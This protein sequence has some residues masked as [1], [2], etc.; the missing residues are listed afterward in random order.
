M[1]R[2]LVPLDGSHL[3]ETVLPDA[4]RL[5]GQGGELILIR[6]ASWTHVDTP[7][8]E[9][10]EW[11]AIQESE[12]YLGSMARRLEK[13]GVRTT[14]YRLTASDVA[15]AIDDAASFLKVDL[16]A[17]AT[18]GRGPLGRL[19]FG[20]IVWKALTESRLPIL[21]CH[22][23]EESSERTYSKDGQSSRQDINSHALTVSGEGPP[24]ADARRRIL[25]PLDG[26]PFGETA[27]PTAKQLAAEWKASLYLA[28]VVPDPSIPDSL[29][30][31]SGE[32]QGELIEAQAYLSRVSKGLDADLHTDVFSGDTVDRL[33]S[34]VGDWGITDIVMSTHGRTGL[35]RVVLGSIADDLVQ[36]G[37]RPTI[38]VPP[39]AVE[40]KTDAKESVS[41][42]VRVS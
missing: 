11:H 5:A 23:E 33:V 26:S 7:L 16:V 32:T 38:V 21:L 18:H 1:R 12:R 27:I 22:P 36:R 30:G 14:A 4:L 13:E 2:V 34:A 37:H 6:D 28:R 40:S 35:K 20:G 29:F 17:C 8:E 31:G 3:A 24:K 39:L 10:S 9:Y 42:C 15:E 25:V 19:L 41:R